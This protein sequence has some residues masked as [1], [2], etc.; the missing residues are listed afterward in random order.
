MPPREKLTPIRILR[1]LA[2]ELAGPSR[3]LGAVL[4]GYQGVRAFTPQP[5]AK[6]LES[7]GNPAGLL[8]SL[9]ALV[10][11]REQLRHSLRAVFCVLDASQPATLEMKR[12]QGFQVRPFIQLFGS[13]F[14]F[15][16]H[17]QVL[18]LHFFM[19]RICVVIDEPVDNSW[20]IAY[21]V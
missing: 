4:V 5:L 6:L 2:S 11:S 17:F 7:V 21:S 1:N 19:S 15:N 8:L 14:F 13:D 16:L 18:P 20:S 9:I 10:R 3:C 12:A